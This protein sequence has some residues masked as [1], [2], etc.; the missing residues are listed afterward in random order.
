MLKHKKFAV[1]LVL[2]LALLTAALEYTNKILIPKYYYNSDWP[3]T[4][5]YL[6][7]Y[8]MDKNSVD[9]LFLGSS[10]CAA[11]FSPVELY[12]KH[13]IRSYNL[14]CE[15]QN[16]LVSYY[17]LLEALRFQSPEYV[18]LDVFML[19]PYNEDEILNTSEESMRKSVDIM[20]WSHV[21]FMAVYD[22][23]RFDTSQELASYLFP[24]GRFHTRWK[25][26]QE[27]DFTLQ[28]M[29]AQETLMGFRPLDFNVDITGYQPFGQIFDGEAAYAEM[30]PAMQVYLD[31]ITA[32]CQDKGIQLVLVKTPTMFYSR[33]AY[34]TVCLY[35]L[36]HGLQYLDFNEET[37]YAAAELDFSTDSCDTDHVS[38]AGALKISDYLGGWLAARGVAG[39]QDT[40]W[41]KRA[42]Y[43]EHC[44]KDK[45]LK[46]ITD[47]GQYMQ[48][49][50]DE[51]YAVFMVMP[52][53]PLHYYTVIDGG[54]ILKEMS[55]PEPLE[56]QG[57][58]RNGL[59]SYRI[60]SDAISI[61]GGVYP[62]LPDGLNIIVY[63]HEK[64]RVIDKV[65]FSIND[66]TIECIR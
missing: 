63:C 31:K 46:K 18:F 53:M 51:A 43:D 21:K 60:G 49:I 52:G 22:I 8:D 1:R 29:A 26:L 61:D 59:T 12:R 6:D 17:W 10:H 9:V 19:F 20:K 55:D 16:L 42:L 48:A 40:Q 3:T 23:C 65:F 39:T 47:Y 32:L 7:F 57:T 11:A 13:G 35:A 62:L 44:Q 28:A 58:V 14:G 2:F 38:A 56:G 54:R 30:V 37:L 24:N 33:E 64:R 66:E 34:N 25:E 41:E 45:N 27:N 4:S 36:E 5:T 50:Q 15:Q